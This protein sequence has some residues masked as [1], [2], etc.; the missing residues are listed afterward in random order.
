MNTATTR[1]DWSSEGSVRA[2]A[3]HDCDALLILP[4]G[5][6]DTFLCPR[7]QCVVLRRVKGG[8]DSPLAFYLAAAVFFLVGNCFPIVQIVAG[9]N[10]L[11][12]TLIGA[13]QALHAQH[14]NLIAILV[15]FTTVVIPAVELFCTTSVLLL[16]ETRHPFSTLAY[17]F[18]L[19]QALRPWNMVEILMLGAIVA[20]V[21]LGSFAS[22]VVGT[23]LWSLAAFMV[24]HA[25]ATHVFDPKEFWNDIKRPP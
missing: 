25:A 9:G 13:V 10:S 1:E 16:A 20:L 15:A 14:M 24:A 23:G 12:T 3:C 18:R 19:R 21:K 6:L 5:V 2:I 22:V 17:F 11:Q 7:C 4:R 8:L